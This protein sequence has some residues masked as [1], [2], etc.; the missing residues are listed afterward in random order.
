MTDI[1]P[2]IRSAILAEPDITNYLA[3]WQSVPGVFTRRPVPED[4]PFP[5]IVVSPEIAYGDEDALR[6][7]RSVITRDVIVYGRVAA[8]GT[9]DD[10]T[11]RVEAVGYLLREL[12]HRQP[13]SL[14]NPAYH[15]ISINATGPRVAPTDSDSIVARVVTLTVRIENK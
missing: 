11:R 1:A 10:H 5:M 6:K 7:F 8:P 12:F 3:P 2:D 14:G 4:A 15:V 9:V 13:R